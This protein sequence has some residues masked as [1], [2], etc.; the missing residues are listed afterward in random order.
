MLG[1]CKCWRSHYIANS[2][3]SML[4]LYSDIILLQNKNRKALFSFEKMK[5]FSACCVSFILNM[6][7]EKCF[8][9]FHWS[10]IV[11]LSKRIK[12]KQPTLAASLAFILSLCIAFF[13]IWSRKKANNPKRKFLSSIVLYPDEN[14]GEKTSVT[15][16]IMFV[17]FS[18]NTHYLALMYLFSFIFMHSVF[19]HLIKKKSK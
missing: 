16:L 18:T 3:Y 7:I 2:V 9:L 10:Y 13:C 8:Y 1:Y 15:L 4:V 14:Q 19:L 6:N 5:V 11:F 12:R 17:I